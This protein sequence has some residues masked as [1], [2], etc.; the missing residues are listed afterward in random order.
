VREPEESF[1]EN[2]PLYRLETLIDILRSYIEHD[3]VTAEEAKKYTP[4]LSRAKSD[5]RAVR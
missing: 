4:H 5:L 1:E 3:Q 2:E